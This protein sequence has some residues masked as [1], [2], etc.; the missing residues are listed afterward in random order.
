MLSNDC[1]ISKMSTSLPFKPFLIKDTK[2]IGN[3]FRQC[4]VPIQELQ[5][6]T[7][8]CVSLSF[9]KIWGLIIKKPIKIASF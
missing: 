6:R 1:Q 3:R 2:C 8:T 9:L 5:K 4:S 7:S